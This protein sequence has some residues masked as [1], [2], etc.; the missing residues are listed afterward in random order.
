MQ[1]FSE[2]APLLSKKLIFEK[3][4]AILIKGIFRGALNAPGKNLFFNF[5]A[6]VGVAPV[7][8]A[9]EAVK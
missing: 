6:A 1:C 7:S 9:S 8:A 2:K 4:Y 5:C 3:I